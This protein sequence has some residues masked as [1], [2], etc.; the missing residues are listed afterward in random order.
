MKTKEYDFSKGKLG[1]VIR[2]PGKTRITIWIDSSTLD[3][4]KEKAER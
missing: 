1:S 3:W 2:H 4:Y